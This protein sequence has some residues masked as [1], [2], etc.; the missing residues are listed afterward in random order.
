MLIQNISSAVPTAPAAGRIS[1][2]A[3][4]VVVVQSSPA[5]Q[6]QPGDSPSPA[7]LK[8]ALDSANH[9]LQQSHQSL[10]FSVDTTTHAP[11]VSV[12]DSETGQVILQFPSKAAIAIAQSI[13]QAEKRQ[14]LL[15]NQKA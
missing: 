6:P 1:N 8:S 13:D 11:V 9:A 4:Q 10:E 12:T 14:G 3:P 5:P 15:L 7:Q 2:D